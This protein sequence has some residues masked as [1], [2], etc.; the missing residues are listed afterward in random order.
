MAGRVPLRKSGRPPLLPVSGWTDDNEWLGALPFEE[1]PHA[2]EPARGFVV[3]ANNRPTAGPVADVIGNDYQEPYR[4]A[5]ITELLDS[6][7]SLDAAAVARQQTDVVSGFARK[8]RQVAVDAFKQAGD[9]A[10][11][12]SLA[13]WD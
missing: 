6:A 7:T 1:H 13:A 12:D 10:R 9:T 5:R 3:T 11:A 2:L 8:H 4:A